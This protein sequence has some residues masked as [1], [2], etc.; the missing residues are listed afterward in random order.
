[1]DTNLNIIGKENFDKMT[2]LVSSQPI[3]LYTTKHLGSAMLIYEFMN[4]ALDRRNARQEQPDQLQDSHVSSQREDRGR[5]LMPVAEVSS[6]NEHT[7]EAG[8]SKP[9]LSKL[10]S[11]SAN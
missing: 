2:N 7:K 8:R 10:S 9:E 5:H 6:L 3:E 1:M 11:G 4:E